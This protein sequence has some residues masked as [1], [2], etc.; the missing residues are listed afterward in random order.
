MYCMRFDGNVCYMRGMNETLLSNA[1]N[2]HTHTHIASVRVWKWLD[3]RMDEG[4][5]N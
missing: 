3:E 2:A 1:R 5:W 4:I